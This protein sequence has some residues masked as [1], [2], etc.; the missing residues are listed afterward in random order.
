MKLG[1]WGRWEEVGEAKIVLLNQ[2]KIV[3]G[4]GRQQEH[5]LNER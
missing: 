3:G 4:Q 5:S 1:V 2:N